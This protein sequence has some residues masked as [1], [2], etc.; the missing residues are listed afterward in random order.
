[1]ENIGIDIVELDR[2]D[3]IKDGFINHVLSNVEKE[4]YNNLPELKRKE[5][6]GGRFAAKEAIIKCL[7]NY[8]VPN[9][10]DIEITNLD[11]GQPVVKYKDYNILISI[12]H[13]K[14]YAVA[15]A[16]LKEKTV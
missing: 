5:F 8:E 10:K 9:M 6:L 7:S 14:H 1:M 2:L 11:N 16:M 3:D 15:I 12:S 4:K 13:E